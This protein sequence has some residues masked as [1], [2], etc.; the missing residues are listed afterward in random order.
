M[1][2]IVIW[3]NNLPRL[4]QTVL[5]ASTIAVPFYFGALLHHLVSET[6]RLDHGMGLALH[7]AIFILLFTVIV[8]LGR[9]FALVRD[10]LQR[11]REE[12]L[13]SLLHAHAHMDRLVTAAL[14]RLD[15]SVKDFYDTFVASV[16]DLQRIVEATYAT[17]EAAF[18]KS[19]IVTER[20]DFEVTFMTL[21]YVD[22]KITIPACANREGRAPRSMLLR[23]DNSEIYENTVTAT[24]FREA[25]PAVHIIEDTRKPAA[26]YQEIYPNETDRIR[27]SIVF[28][29]LSNKNELLGTLVVH[30]DSVA[31]FQECDKKYWSELLEVFAKRL[32]CAKAKLDALTELRRTSP[33]FRP[34]FSEREFF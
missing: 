24:V 8:A 19:P 22:M 27:S 3:F 13:A 34:L 11:L 4:A 12:R 21:S 25:R 33:D 32:A 30:C 28:P 17:L 23:K 26:N 9:H 15:A 29:V 18:G 2:R 20:I 1:H 5:S 6:A 7:A 10:D 31:F 14:E 16:G